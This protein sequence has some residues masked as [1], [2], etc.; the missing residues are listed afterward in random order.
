MTAA[1]NLGRLTQLP[2]RTTAHHLAATAGPNPFPDTDAATAHQGLPPRHAITTPTFP[3]TTT[4]PPTPARA[5]TRT[6]D[7]ER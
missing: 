7:I 3:S 1:Q 4:R 5:P 6:P 2:A